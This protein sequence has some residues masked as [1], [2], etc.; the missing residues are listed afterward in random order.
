MPATFHAADKAQEAEIDTRNIRFIYQNRGEYWFSEENDPSKRFTLPEEII[1]QS[2]KFLKG[3]TIVETLM[4]GEDDEKK[5]FGVKIPIKMDLLVK[6]APP[7]IKGD[8]ASGGGKLVTLETGA[9]VTAPLFVNQ[10]DTIRI[11]T[12]TGEY[13]E[14]VEKK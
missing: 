4:F 8:T 11:N 1:G 10:G 5:I 7:S 3:N 12:E 6:D 2:A 13:V 14:R 9:T